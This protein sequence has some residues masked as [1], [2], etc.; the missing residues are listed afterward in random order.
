M[1]F[2]YTPEQEGFREELQQWL[3]ENMKELP[4]WY[5]NSDLKSPHID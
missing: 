2:L 3:T 1:D 4:N 5:G